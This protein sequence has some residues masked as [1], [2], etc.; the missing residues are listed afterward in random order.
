M[1]RQELIE[2]LQQ[3]IEEDYGIELTTTDATELSSSLV[4][5]FGI[6]AKN[7]HKLH[8]DKYDNKTDKI[9]R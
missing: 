2:E 5:Y 3:I 7:H 6:L 1:V 8:K 4:N 9:T